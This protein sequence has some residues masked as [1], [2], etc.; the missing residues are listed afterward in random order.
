MYIILFVLRYTSAHASG[1]FSEDS[2]VQ[3]NRLWGQKPTLYKKMSSKIWPSSFKKDK[4]TPLSPNNF[5]KS[6]SKSIQLDFRSLYPSAQL[7]KQPVLNGILLTAAC[8]EDAY[9]LSQRQKIRKKNVLAINPVCQRVRKDDRKELFMMPINHYKTPPHRFEE[10]YATRL[11]AQKEIAPLLS[12]E[13]ELISIA[14]ASYTGKWL[15]NILFSN[16]SM[17]IGG[18]ANICGFYPDLLAVLDS[19][20]RNA[21]RLILYYYHG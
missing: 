15:Y 20:K 8:K 1:I 14:G 6:V 17:S 16:I 12:E 3:I 9:L 19:S 4:K 21:R 13:Y 7:R 11:F 5:K 18:I 2:G 10:Y